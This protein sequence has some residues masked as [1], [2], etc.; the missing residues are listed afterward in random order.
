MSACS[1]ERHLQECGQADNARG[2][3]P[4]LSCCQIRHSQQRLQPRAAGGARGSL[5][6]DRN[7]RPVLLLQPDGPSCLHSCTTSAIKMAAQQGPA[8]HAARGLSCYCSRTPPAFLHCE[9]YESC[10][11]QG[12]SATHA[13][14]TAQKPANLGGPWIKHGVTSIGRAQPIWVKRRRS[15]GRSGYGLG[16]QAGRDD[17][18]QG[19]TPS[20]LSPHPG[21]RLRS[22]ASTHPS[23]LRAP[24]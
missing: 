4:V 22:A 16:G 12:D 18:P 24:L 19:Q 7:L 5:P 13:G 8:E 9:C 2:L 6:T 17:A 20:L 11:S 10:R 14:N 1:I 3:L 21:R 23:P 15:D